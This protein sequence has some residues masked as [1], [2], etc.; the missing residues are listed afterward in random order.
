MKLNLIGYAGEA[1]EALRWPRRLGWRLW[2]VVD[3]VKPR[4][5]SLSVGLEI[6]QIKT[7]ALRRRESVEKYNHLLR[8]EKELGR[9]ATTPGGYW[10]HIAWESNMDIVQ[11]ALG[12][13]LYTIEGAISN[14]CSPELLGLSV[15]LF[16]W[17][18][19]VDKNSRIQHHWYLEESSGTVLW[20]PTT[21]R[22]IKVI[23]YPFWGSWRLLKPFWLDAPLACYKN[24]RTRSSDLLCH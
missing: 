8:V 19:C 14:M 15:L 6:R 10:Q 23:D 11:G 2:Q 13:V 24:R 16:L 22:K 4:I 17:R 7:S 21:F 5:V 1:I 3:Q 12:T 20:L 18:L 9:N